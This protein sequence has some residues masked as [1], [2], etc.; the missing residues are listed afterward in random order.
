M[1]R[2]SS[3]LA[4][5]LLVGAVAS[6]SPVPAQPPET[7]PPQPPI[8]RDQPTAPGDARLP[9]T[10]PQD[11]EFA[12]WMGHMESDNTA[13]TEVGEE[14]S[15]ESLG[16]LLD[17]GH[18]ST[19]VEASAIGDIEFHDYSEDAIENETIGVLD[20]RAS[21]ALVRDRFSW[22]FRENYSE[23]QTD[24]FAAVGPTNREGFNAVSSGPRLETPLGQR[25]RLLGNGTYSE[26]RYEDSTNFDTNAVLYELGVFRQ[27]T[28]SAE[29]GLTASSND[30]DY[31]DFASPP[32][33]IRRLALRYAK[34]LP[35]GR[36]LIEAGTNEV[37]S[38]NVTTNEPVYNLE[39]ISFPAPRSRFSIAATEEF[40]D[41]GS[42]LTDPVSG[43]PGG[44]DILVAANPLEQRRFSLSYTLALGRTD[45]SIALSASQDSYLGDTTL[46][47][48]H[49]TA[50]ATFHRAMSLRVG[51][52]LTFDKAER[53]F[54]NAA[55]DGPPDEDTTV[56][57]WVYRELGRRFTL[58]IAASRYER[59][60]PQQ[61]DEERYEV[62]FAYSPTESALAAMNSV[63]R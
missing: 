21:L 20:A 55:V 60:G 35:S 10:E 36:L 52:G 59:R 3:P 2:V 17:V 33:Q 56:S 23:G 14:G 22:V 26:R 29:V 31:V 40:T 62:R 30:I 18:V 4:C 42:L 9:A 61:F 5:L 19:F 47:N 41:S 7:M 34:V 46:D 53:E 57:A 12:V 27:V 13:R 37:S 24:A 38:D 32:Y 45:L 16:L 28:R 43:G 58:A 15:Y 51:I 54:T 49:V 6:N 11:R 39:W 1:S 25:S 8:R 48:D 63:G 44:A 50:R